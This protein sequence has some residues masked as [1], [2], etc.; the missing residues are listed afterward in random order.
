MT[1]LSQFGAA[2]GT[3]AKDDRAWDQWT[4]FSEV[5]GFDPVVSREIAVQHSDL[6]ASRLGLFLLWVYP[7]IKGKGRADAHPRS[8]LNNYP[9]AIVRILK[10]DH[11][12]PVPRAATYE[13]EV[14]GLLRGYKRIYGTLA[15]APKR[16]QPMTRSLWARVEQ[17]QQ[18]Q[19]LTGRGRWLASQAHLDKVGVRLGRIL[20][21]TAHRLGEVVAYSSEISY[22][23]REH[24]TYRIGGIIYVDPEPSTLTQMAAGDMVFLAPCSSKPDQFGEE[25][26]TF[27]SVMRFDGP[28]SAAAAVR[29]IEIEKP[30]RG[31]HRRTMPLFADENGAPYDYYTLNKW[32]R[33]VLTAL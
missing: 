4:I 28:L 10:R 16:R 6:L 13:A 32:L 27:P 21:S 11:K 8:V 5:Y 19:A 2:E 20:A 1:Q 25:H 31:L 29:D 26:C 17:L 12:L 14:K 23:T 33:E 7:R 18:G 30:C 24:V 22:L 3:L 15:L 9:V